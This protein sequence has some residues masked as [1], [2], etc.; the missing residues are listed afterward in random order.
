MMK[1]T[2]LVDSRRRIDANIHPNG[3]LTL[4]G[5]PAAMDF[6]EKRGEVAK[7]EADFRHIFTIRGAIVKRMPP[8]DSRR[9][10]DANISQNGILTFGAPAAVD[11]F[12]K[13]G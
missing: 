4:G 7:I 12:E 8:V 9:R 13:R 5:A 6:F 11:F 2:L 3:I 10:I 1:Q